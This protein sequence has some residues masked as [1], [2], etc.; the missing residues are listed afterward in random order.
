MS[1]ELRRV[2]S[3][4][5]VI[6][7]S[8]IEML[9]PGGLELSRR[10]GEVVRLDRSQRVLDVSS[11]RGVT[12]SFYAA[13]FG[14]EVVGLDINERFVAEAK[15]RAADAGLSSRVSFHVGDSRKLPFAAG[16]FDVVINECAVGLTA[17]GAP[18]RVLEEMARVAKP[19]AAVVIHEST[20]RKP[21][22]SV[23]REEAER[24]IG[25]APHSTEEWK[26]M[27]AQAGCETVLVEDWSGVENLQK[28]RPNHHWRKGAPLDGFTWREKATLLPRVVAE[29]G[30]ASLWDL[31]RAV[32]LLESLYLDG[33]LG[34]ALL[35]ARK[36]ATA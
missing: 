18:Q 25:T 31:H 35:V 22:S 32:R 8:G 24:R 3:G 11:G 27:L 14:C 29:F 23:R 19:G 34:Y 28:M 7:L 13:Q 12:A 9:H 21:L 16:E 10:I 1:G 17:I 6:E 30:L 26:A 15:R 2:V 20:W 36:V 33:D 5:D 4:E